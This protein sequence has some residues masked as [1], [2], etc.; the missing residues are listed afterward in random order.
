MTR[1][2][3]VIELINNTYLFRFSGVVPIADRP[4]EGPVEAM[5][6]L[7]D[8]LGV[9]PVKAVDLIANILPRSPA[10]VEVV[11]ARERVNALLDP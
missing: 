4:L 8:R 5:Q 7:V 9:S 10:H 11:L 3:I 1:M 2:S 6:F